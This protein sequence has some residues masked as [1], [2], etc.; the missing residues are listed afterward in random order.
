MVSNFGTHYKGFKT[1]D[2]SFAIGKKRVLLHG[3]QQGSVREVKTV[4]WIKKQEDQAQLSMIFVQEMDTE[5]DM[6]LYSMEMDTKR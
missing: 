3:I 1:L 6:L 4:N 5:D 2:I